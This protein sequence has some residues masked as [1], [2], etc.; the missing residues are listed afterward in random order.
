VA[1]LRSPCY[2]LGVSPPVTDP[3]HLAPSIDLI[4]QSRV[5]DLGGFEV[6]RVLPAP[7]RRRVG[8]FVFWDHMGPATFEP[9]HG[10]EV[11]P[12][13]H[14]NLA[15]VTYLFEG[16]IVHRDS[17]GSHQSI[18]AGAVNWMI[19][20]RGIVHSERKPESAK[21]HVTCAH[22][23]QAWV[24]LPLSHEETEPSFRHHPAD[25]LPE[26][27]R[28]GLRLRVLAGTA[29][30]R[31]SPV[32]VLSPTLYVDAALEAGAEL[33]LPEE[34]AE[35]A[36]YVALG[37]VSCEGERVSPGAMVI[38]RPGVPS[39]VRALADSRV[40]LLGGAPMDGERHVYWNFVSSSMD[41]SERAK[42]DWKEGRFP[43]V[44]GDEAEFIPPPE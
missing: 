30:G 40:M 23:I 35:R 42:R 17:L 11:R 8:P 5:R 41:R 10:V 21:N 6:R 20:G 24:A 39:V 25:S 3:I 22:G 14:I 32:Q 15:T 19:A 29:F 2:T 26:V 28:P 4:V 34:H 43:K 37:S 33:T 16:E 12:H 36:V 31:A 44:P 27:R 9:G 13:P 1:A 7:Q 18:R 38:L